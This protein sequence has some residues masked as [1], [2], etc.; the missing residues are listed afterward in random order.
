MFVFHIFAAVVCFDTTADIRQKKTLFITKIRM[1]LTS[2]QLAQLAYFDFAA[3]T[4]VV[5]SF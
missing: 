4:V 3:V 1:E 5:K 2:F